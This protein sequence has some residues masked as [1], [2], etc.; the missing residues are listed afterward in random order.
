MDA[1]LISFFTLLLR[2]SHP[3]NVITNRTTKEEFNMDNLFLNIIAQ[4]ISS[5][6]IELLKPSV[7][8][9]RKKRIRKRSAK[10]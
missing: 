7:K 10:L 5:L 9:F 1:L 6:A 2:T 3:W 8:D 4:I